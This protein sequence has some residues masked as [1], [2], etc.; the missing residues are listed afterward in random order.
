[1]TSASIVAC[2]RERLDAFEGLVG[3]GAEAARARADEDHRPG[4]RFR[5]A[6]GR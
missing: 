4:A 1:M 5:G 6:G 3:A 2:G